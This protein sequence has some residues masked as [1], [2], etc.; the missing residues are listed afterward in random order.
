M[1]LPGEK[2]YK[3]AGA[4]ERTTVVGNGDRGDGCEEWTQKDY[5][6][7]LLFIHPGKGLRTKKTTNILSL[8]FF[9]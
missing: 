3:N 2:T 9:F 8:F 5:D 6:R 1:R 4:D 7:A